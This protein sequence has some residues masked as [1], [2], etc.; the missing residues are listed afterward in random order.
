MGG[1]EINHLF[2]DDVLIFCKGDAYNIRNVKGILL[3]FENLSG[4]KVSMDKSR[5]Y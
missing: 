1:L 5:L 4:P 3:K 2:V